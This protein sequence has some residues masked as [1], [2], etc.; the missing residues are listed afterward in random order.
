MDEIRR[1]VLKRWIELGCM[2]TL[3][4]CQMKVEAELKKRGLPDGIT[5]AHY[6]DIAGIDD[7]R[8][9]RLLILVGRTA[10]GPDK[11]EEIA[12]AL[13]G[14]RPMKSRPT[15]SPGTER[16][17][18]ASGCLMAAASAPGATCTLIAWSRLSAGR[19]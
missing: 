18:A 4:V 16:S 1:Y 10:P 12:G 14:A 5:V 6:N 7:W 2:S 19:C 11:M 13:S 3:V 17:S 9:V 15:A 8:D